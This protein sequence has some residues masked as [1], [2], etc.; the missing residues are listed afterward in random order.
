M[1]YPAAPSHR[2]ANRYV[3]LHSSSPQFHYHTSP[4]FEPYK[5]SGSAWLHVE[6]SVSAPSV[7]THNH[8]GCIEEK[9]RF[10]EQTVGKRGVQTP[11]QM[12]YTLWLNAQ[13]CYKHRWKSAHIR[14]SSSGSLS[15]NIED[16]RPVLCDYFQY[17]SAILD[18]RRW[19]ELFLFSKICMCF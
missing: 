11:V 2:T 16:T 8:N 3:P 14:A 10:S 18:E 6:L 12:E 17:S 5:L 15:R 19:T 4:C 7:R 1:I 9:A 13:R